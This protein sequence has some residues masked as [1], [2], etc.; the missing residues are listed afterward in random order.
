MFVKNVAPIDHYLSMDGSPGDATHSLAP[1]F[2]QFA[3]VGR[4][5]AHRSIVPTTSHVNWD[6]RPYCLF[7]FGC[8]PADTASARG[9]LHG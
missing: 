2:V 4:P 5:S 3:M 8:C 1:R 9:I 7:S 6:W